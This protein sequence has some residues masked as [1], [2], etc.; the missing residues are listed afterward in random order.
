MRIFSTPQ[1][2]EEAIAPGTI[3]AMKVMKHNVNKAAV[4]MP[5]KRKE[6]ELWIMYKINGGKVKPTK[7][8]LE[9]LGYKRPKTAKVTMISAWRYPG[10]TKPGERPNIPEGLMEELAE[11][12]VI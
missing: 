4:G 3:G 11:E 8:K 2:R 1:R 12:G 9:E 5:Q 7:S 6:T 10:R